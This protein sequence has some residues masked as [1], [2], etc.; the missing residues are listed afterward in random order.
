MN[1][2]FFYNPRST[3]NISFKQTTLKLMNDENIANNTRNMSINKSTIVITDE[4]T[5][6]EFGKD[7]TNLSNQENINPNQRTKLVDIK[8]VI[9]KFKLFF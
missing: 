7:L 8:N 2:T 3:G 4:K 6:R 9:L 1:S 5:Q